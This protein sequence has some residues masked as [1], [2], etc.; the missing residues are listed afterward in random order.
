MLKRAFDIGFSAFILVATAPLMVV[1]ALG[2]KL[3]SPG[4]IFYRA[5]RMGVGERPFSM[6]KFR[7]MHVRETAG[8]EISAVN[9]TRIFGFGHF[10]RATKIDELPQFFNVLIGDMAIVGPRP[11]SV[12]IV[13]SSYLPW[14]METLAVRPGVTSPGALFGYTHANALLDDSD[15]DGSYERFVLAPKLAV[16]LAYIHRATFLS[17]V[18]VMIQTA[19]IIVQM[20]AGKHDFP[21]PRDAQANRWFD[22]ARLGQAA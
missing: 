19:L 1:A 2:I 22:F 3:T 6:W 14:M 18:G 12:A 13:H 15:P 7:T 20:V 9:D 5:N 8:P 17:D 10:L 4:P 16:E 21:L 11:E